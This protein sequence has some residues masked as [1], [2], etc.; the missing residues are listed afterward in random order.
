ML[1]RRVDHL[2]LF[3]HKGAMFLGKINKDKKQRFHAVV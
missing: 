2:E 1:I 3:G